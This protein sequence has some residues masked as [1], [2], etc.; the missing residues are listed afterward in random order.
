MTTQLLKRIG[1][2]GGTFDPIQLAHLIIA[3]EAQARLGLSR[4][5][6]IPAGEPWRKRGRRISS[7]EHRVAMVRLAI[8]DDPHFELSLV[9]VERPGSSYTADTL[10]EMRRLLGEETEL[11]F[12]LG[13]DALYDLPHW[14]TPE[15]IIEQCHLVAVARPGVSLRR[16][17]EVKRR[18]PVLESKLVMLPAPRIEVSSSDI[19]RRVA[20]GL[21]IRYLVPPQVEAYIEQHRLY[22]D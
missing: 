21:P 17:G 8:A 4:V 3:S 15:L 11:Y 1:L 6:F 19:R 18:L 16:L 13:L 14:R 2:L 22:R 5:L 9:E 12:I 7:T 20:A 10:Q